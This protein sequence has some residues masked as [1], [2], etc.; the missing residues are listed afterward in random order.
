[1]G[2]VEVNLDSGSIEMDTDATQTAMTA[3][4]L[5]GSYLQSVLTPQLQ[6][7]KDLERQ[8]GQGPLGRPFADSY[9]AE[10]VPLE[11]NTGV[12]AG[13]PERFA[14]SGRSVIA[15]YVRVEAEIT[16]ALQG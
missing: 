6:H 8:L 3:M 15:S 2:Q 13:I 10:V 5:A 9:N 14:A 16:A 7:I 12:L 4:E 11:Q 1:M